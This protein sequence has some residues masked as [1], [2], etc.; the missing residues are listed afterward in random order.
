MIDFRYHV[1]SLAAVLVALSIGIVLGAGPLKDNI[2]STL[3]GEVTKLREDK[4]NLRKENHEHQEAIEARDRFEETLL[5]GA[6][7]GQLSGKSVALVLLPEADEGTT[8][9]VQESLE[10]SG[11]KVREPVAV[12]EDW[13][14]TDEATRQQR[15]QVGARAL[16]DLEV[17]AAVPTQAQRVDQALAVV[18][19]GSE[20]ADGADRVP[21]EAR[22]RAWSRLRGADLL[23]A[24]E[25]VPAAA[26]L[27]VVVGGPV[28]A[29][30]DED[31][32]SIDPA[33][34]ATAA[35]WVALTHVLHRH[36]EGCVLTASAEDAGPADASPVTMARTRGS[37]ADGVST[38]DV[39]ELPMG[40][41]DIVLA[42]VEQLEEGHGHYGLAA[43]ADA[44]VPDLS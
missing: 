33:A 22:E 3:S 34:E 42:L 43:D 25:Q 12:T 18:L 9:G 5:P 44:A 35:H 7:S 17:E 2:G 1:V 37:L 19:S 6:V 20:R 16:E 41:A 29:Q 26:D 4:E 39:P 21:G 32:G 23:D 30:E 10:D 27:L 11:A 28:P 8:E 40:R 24:E 36:V 14:S 15:S 13:A 31:S 38:V